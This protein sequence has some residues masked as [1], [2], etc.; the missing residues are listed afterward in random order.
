MEALRGELAAYA[1]RI[2]LAR[3]HEGQIRAAAEIRDFLAGSQWTTDRGRQVRLAN[4]A[5]APW[6]PRVQD[7]Y[8]LRCAPQVHGAAWD[9]LAFAQEV[10][11]REMNGALDNPLI[12]P[13]AEGGDYE[14]LSGATSTA[15]M[16]S[17]PTSS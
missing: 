6:Q 3:N 7:A 8:A 9:L 17:P 11:E 10:I 1:E 13:T 4:D 15:Q 14:A 12:F 5:G 16:P 2:H